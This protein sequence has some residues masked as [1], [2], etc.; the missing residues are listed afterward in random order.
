MEMITCERCG[1]VY[2]D[3]YKSCPYC[4]HLSDLNERKCPKCNMLIGKEFVYCPNC[5]TDVLGY[6]QN[7]IIK[8]SE[9]SSTEKR[10]PKCNRLI[11][12]G[13]KYCP[14][15]GFE[16]SRHKETLREE[17]VSNIVMVILWC[18][19]I[20]WGPLRYGIKS[21]QAIEVYRG[22]FISWIVFLLC[23]K[24]LN[25]FW[26]YLWSI[27]AFFIGMWPVYLILVIGYLYNLVKK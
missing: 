15:C 11:E 17:P 4:G 2:S 21:Y 22:I 24:K 25:A 20:Y 18:F 6:E 3:F 5:G 19:Y 27:I 7:N 8:K 13:N 26:T 10:C 16:L 12:S 9:L 14:N 1:R 23:R